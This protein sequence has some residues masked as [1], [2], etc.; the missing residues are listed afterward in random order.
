[1]ARVLIFWEP[2]KQPHIHTQ[3][4]KIGKTIVRDGNMSH[5]VREH[6]RNSTHVNRKQGNSTVKQKYRSILKNIQFEKRQHPI[7]L[8]V[9]WL[10]WPPSKRLIRVR[11]PGGASP[12]G[13]LFANLVLFSEW[14][15]FGE[16]LSPSIC[17]SELSKEFIIE[18]LAREETKEIEGRKR[19]KQI[20]CAK[21]KQKSKKAIICISR[22]D[23]TPDLPRVRRT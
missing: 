20:V 7:A 6:N 21:Q 15:R 14:I 5:F 8:L 18:K 17:L 23:R 12:F 2:F 3:F 13:F 11:F 10:V 1:M 19:N 4:R 9:Q 22:E 16:S